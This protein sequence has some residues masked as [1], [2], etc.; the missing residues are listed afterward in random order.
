M[1]PSGWLHPMQAIAGGTGAVTVEEHCVL[2]QRAQL[3]AVL[4]WLFVP[5]CS[6]PTVFEGFAEGQ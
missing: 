2:L 4:L 6:H 5:G 3:G 1:Q